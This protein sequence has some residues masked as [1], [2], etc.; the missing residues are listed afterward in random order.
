MEMI[1]GDRR[2]DRRYDMQLKLHYRLMK[3]SRVLHEGTGITR[4][5]SRG[6]I[7]FEADRSLQSGSLVELSIEWPIPLRGRTPIRLHVM[8]YVTR[9][10]RK[11]VALHSTWH[12]FVAAAVERQPEPQAALAI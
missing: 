2:T 1:Q 9:S 7:Q 12:E 3:G 4:N 6:G 5:M 11:V 8:G 10:C